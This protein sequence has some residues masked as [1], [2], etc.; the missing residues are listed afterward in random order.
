LAR[1]ED[2]PGYSP[3]VREEGVRVNVRVALIPANIPEIN[4]RKR[5]STRLEVSL[6]VINVRKRESCRKGTFLTF[7][8]ERRNQAGI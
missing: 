5:P 7:L 2:Y 1:R 6:S 4:D 8:R 3:R